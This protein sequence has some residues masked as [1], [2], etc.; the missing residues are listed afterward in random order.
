MRIRSLLCSSVFA[1]S[2]LLPAS[3]LAADGVLIVQTVSDGAATTAA[4]GRVQLEAN[5]VRTEFTDDNGR[6]QVV[7]Y[8][9]TKDVV[10]MIDAAGGSYV[11]ITRADA[12]QVGGMMQGA[13]A[14]MAEQL[15]RMPPEQRRMMEQKMGAMMGGSAAVAAPTFTRAGTGRVGQWDCDRYDGHA[16]G[17]K[18]TE[19]C[20]VAPEAL[21]LVAADFAVLTKLSEFVRSMAPQLANQIVGLG[22]AEQG[23]SGLP[24]RTASTIDGRT[25]TS[26]VTEVRRA[27]FEDSIFQVPAGLKKRSLMGAMGQ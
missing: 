20:T 9:G 6:R 14:M 22:T 18:V 11:E 13:M 2:A 21:G 16:G 1:V 10:W 7:I 3:V 15:A 25:I 5:R 26:Q 8:D 19:I 4:S 12:Q 17:Q 24:V 23:F 27:T